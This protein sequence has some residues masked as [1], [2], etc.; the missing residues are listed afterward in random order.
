MDPRLEILR[1]LGVLDWLTEI[2]GADPEKIVMDID[3]SF[4]SVI[5]RLAD[6]AES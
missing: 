2:I 5:D 4:E 1:N 3:S 6:A